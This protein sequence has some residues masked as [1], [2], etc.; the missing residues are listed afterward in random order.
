[1]CS[2]CRSARS[3]PRSP[4]SRRRRAA[5]DRWPTSSASPTC[6]RHGGGSPAGVGVAAASDTKSVRMAITTDW[7]AGFQLT[8]DAT[9]LDDVPPGGEYVV[10]CAPQANA[11]LS[12]VTVRGFVLDRLYA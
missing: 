3:R 5:T 2:T 10:E 6:T 1:M 12:D 7:D 4:P 11:V 9:P 8:A